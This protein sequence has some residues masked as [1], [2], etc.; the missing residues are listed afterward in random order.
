MSNLISICIPAYKNPTLLKRL[1]DSIT[2][3]TFKDF[4]IIITDDSPNNEIELLIEIYKS[5]FASLHYFKNSHSLGSPENWNESIRKASGKWIKIMHH[6][7]FFLHKDA[8]TIFASSAKNVTIENFI[9]SGFQ[10]ISSDK[11]IKDYIISK[12]NKK[13]LK[14]SALNLFKFNFIGTSKHYFN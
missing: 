3:Q 2:M 14:Q 4:E 8:L 7:D 5:R 13:L 11:L 1:L 9:F 6:D 10:E 12:K